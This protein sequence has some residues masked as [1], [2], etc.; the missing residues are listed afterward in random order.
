[1]LRPYTLATIQ[2]F[3]KQFTRDLAG[4]YQACRQRLPGALAATFDRTCLGYEDS[5]GTGFETLDDLQ[6]I[7]LE[8]DT[9][10]GLL[11][12][13]S[14]VITSH[15]GAD[16]SGRALSP[17][18]EIAMLS[19]RD[20]DG[21]PLWTPTAAAG[22]TVGQL[23]GRQVIKSFNVGDPDDD[24]VQSITISDQATLTDVDGTQ[25]NLWQ[26]NMTAVR[27]ECEVGFGFRDEDRFVRLKH[28]G[29]LTPPAKKAAAKKVAE[30]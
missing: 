4:R 21:H 26:R 16:L 15:A 7:N 30:A 22:G 29:T 25:L 27:A 20:N 18:G 12:A 11:E 9:Y 5:P 3:S 14:S 1:V 23:L 6:V 10:T 2:P 17:V 28:S 24:I 8:P 19:A 13:M